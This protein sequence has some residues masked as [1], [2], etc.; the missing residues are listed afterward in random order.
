MPV[1]DVRA[2]VPALHEFPTNCRALKK[3]DAW[4]DHNNSAPTISKFLY[5]CRMS[6]TFIQSVDNVNARRA[7]GFNIAKTS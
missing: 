3:G 2:A 7:A 4:T 1:T 5:G 6:R